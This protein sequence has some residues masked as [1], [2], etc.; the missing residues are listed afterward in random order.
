MVRW[1]GVEGWKRGNDGRVEGWKGRRM[2]GRKDG[3]VEGWKGG[4]NG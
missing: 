4:K 3:R 2:E 1:K